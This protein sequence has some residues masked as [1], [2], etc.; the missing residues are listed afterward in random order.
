MTKSILV[1]EGPS[2]YLTD[3]PWKEDRGKDV[4]Y[5]LYALPFGV[6]SCQVSCF[7]CG[8]KPTL[9]SVVCQELWLLEQSVPE[10]LRPTESTYATAARGEQSSAG[11]MHVGTV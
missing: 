9:E 2:R 1:Q 11:K 8:A 3:S 10:R 5:F 4:Y 6:F 7:F